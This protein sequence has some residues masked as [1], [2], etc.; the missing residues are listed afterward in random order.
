MLEDFCLSQPSEGIL[1]ISFPMSP[2]MYGGI[3]TLKVKSLSSVRFLF[4]FLKTF[5][6]HPMLLLFDRNTIW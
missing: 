3:Y 4:M 5:F 2:G 6:S 1:G